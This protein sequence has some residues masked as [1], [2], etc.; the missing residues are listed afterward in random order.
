MDGHC[1]HRQYHWLLVYI[2]WFQKMQNTVQK[3]LINFTAG[4]KSF[5]FTE[6]SAAYNGKFGFQMYSIEEVVK[7]KMSQ[8]SVVHWGLGM[9]NNATFPQFFL[10]P[11]HIMQPISFWRP[12]SWIGVGGFQCFPPGCRRKLF[13]CL[14]QLDVIFA[15]SLKDRSTSFPPSITAPSARFPNVEFCPFCQP[16]IF[17]LPLSYEKLA[18]SDH[19]QMDKPFP[20][21]WHLGHDSIKLNFLKFLKRCLLSCEKKIKKKG[22][23]DPMRKDGA[24]RVVAVKAS[25]LPSI[26]ADALRHADILLSIH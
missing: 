25:L 18:N 6:S 22:L 16:E 12:W 7:N 1:F 4:G 2:Q 13:V 24:R 21:Y 3:L 19:R 23:C 11:V 15:F 5:H 10:G 20:Q 9:Y 26:G 14:R 8:R 17:H